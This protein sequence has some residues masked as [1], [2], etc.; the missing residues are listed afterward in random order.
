MTMHKALHPRDDVDRL[1]RSRKEE[2]RELTSIENSVDASIQRFED[3]IE[4]KGGLIVAIKND[5]DNTKTERM[6][7]TRK[8]G[9]KSKSMGNLHD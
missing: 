1:Y 3:Y 7:I 9:K 4:N 8:N 5:T 2:G 6:T